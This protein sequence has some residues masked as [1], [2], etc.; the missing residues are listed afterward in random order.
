MG[1]RRKRAP[2]PTDVRGPQR[3][4]A[5]RS[6]ANGSCWPVNTDSTGASTITTTETVTSSPTVK[7]A[8]ENLRSYAR[9]NLAFDLSVTSAIKEIQANEASV[10]D[11]YHA[12]YEESLLALTHQL[13]IAKGRALTAE[14]VDQ[15]LTWHAAKFKA[16]AEEET[17]REAA[18]K[19]AQ[20]GALQLGGYALVTFILLVFAFIFVKI[21]RNLRAV[22][23]AAE[24]RA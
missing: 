2:R 3:T 21:E 23:V 20:M 5:I 13:V 9:R 15:L 14:N 19:V 16:A 17:A 11:A 24:L 12:P 6:E 18:A 4:S 1:R 10:P 7:Q 22:A 8:A